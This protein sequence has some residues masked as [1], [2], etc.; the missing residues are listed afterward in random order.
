[1]KIRLGYGT[2]FQEAEVPEDNIIKTLEQNDVASDAK[3]SDIIRRA[4]EEPIGTKRLRDIVKPG[5]KVVIIT[6]D[7][8]RPMPTWEALPHVLEE[9][10]SAGAADDDITVVFALG[11]HRAHTEEERRR[12]AGDA[13]DR[14]KCVDS[15]PSDC[16]HL[17]TTRRGTPVDIT[18]AVALADRIILL[19]NIEYHYFA[20]YS[21]GIK[22]LM[23]G[24]STPEAIQANHSMMVE[25]AA[26]AGNEIIDLTAQVSFRRFLQGRQNGHAFQILNARTSGTDEMDMILRVPIKTLHTVHGSK[27]CDQPL[28]FEQ[29]QVSVHRSQ[30]EVRNFRLQLGV[31]PLSRGMRFGLTQAGQNGVALPKVLRRSFHSNLLCFFENHSHLQEDC[32]IAFLICQ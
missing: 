18:K 10:S 11:S 9:L 8:T 13:Y 14:I 16:L 3:A 2:G 1:M 20:G 31:Y 32:I 4:L 26:C 24:A 21:G 17:G 15:D 5:E 23:P 19:G 6:S 7:I 12:L 29:R 28:G 27:A 30:G 25:A 22:A